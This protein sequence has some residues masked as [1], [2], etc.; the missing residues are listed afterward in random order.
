MRTTLRNPALKDVVDPRPGL[1]GRNRNDPLLFEP[2]SLLW[3]CMTDTVAV[4]P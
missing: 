1:L 2:G 4:P 3:P